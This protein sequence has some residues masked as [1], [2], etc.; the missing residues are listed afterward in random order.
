MRSSGLGKLYLG[1]DDG[2]TS[3]T[4]SLSYN[5]QG[6]H[7]DDADDIELFNPDSLDGRSV[8][9][10]DSLIARE[11]A[12]LS[13]EDREQVRNETLVSSSSLEIVIVIHLY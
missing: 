5:S 6:S 1:N 13:M 7:G 2:S 8:A 11:L 12:Q 4:T 10:A 3:T 9:T